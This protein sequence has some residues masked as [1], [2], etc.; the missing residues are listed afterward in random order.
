[1]SSAL[2]AV[3]VFVLV[4]AG[5]LAGVAIR[6]PAQHQDD[7]TKDVVKLV[8]GLVATMTALVL[9]LLIASAH[10]S[11][12]RQESEV[13]QLGAQ[14]VQ[15]DEL[16]VHYGPEA[17][18]SRLQLR[19]MVEAELARLWSGGRCQGTAARAASEHLPPSR[20]TCSP[21]SPPWR[22]LPRPSDRRRAAR[23]SS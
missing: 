21:P 19:R 16:F 2:V 13:Q 5:A 8:M 1:M 11:Y 12:D 9:S 14:V 6:V 10:T 18:A 7:E 22:R 3:I 4:F 17:N 23:C 20:K 15:L